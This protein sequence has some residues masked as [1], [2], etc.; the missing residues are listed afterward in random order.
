M[1]GRFKDIGFFLCFFVAGLQNALGPIGMHMYMTGRAGHGP[2]AIACD[3]LNAMVNGHLHYRP[4]FRR[5]KGL[6]CAIG[7]QKGDFRHRRLFK[8]LSVYTGLSRPPKS[9]RSLRVLWPS[10]LK[11]GGLPAHGNL[12][13]AWL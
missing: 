5:F 6:C 4:V 8:I 11:A 1:N 7:L 12:A 13:P 2:A 10:P 3:P 9:G